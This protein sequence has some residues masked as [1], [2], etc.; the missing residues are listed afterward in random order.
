[1]E[2]KE[3]DIIIV[4]AGVAGL[5]LARLLRPDYRVLILERRA[6]PAGGQRIGESLP[7]A[8]SVLLQELGLLDR[9]LS[10][11][12]RM[13]G[14][15][16][17][18]WDQEFPVWQDA[19]RDPAGPGWLLDRRAF[20]QL[21]YQGAIEAGAVIQ[22]GC[23][24]IEITH[25]DEN[26]LGDG[27]HRGQSDSDNSHS[28]EWQVHLS[29]EGLTH[30]AP[31]LIDATGRSS[32]IARTLGLKRLA[33][34]SL[35]CLY[36]FLTCRPEDEDATLR[37]YADEHGWWYTVQ[38][39]HGK[40]VLAYHLEAKDPLWRRIRKPKTFLDHARRHPF[41][42]ETIQD[43]S[44]AALKIHPAG[45][46]MLDIANLQQAGRGFLAIGDALI[47]FDPIS[48][49]G[50]FHALATATSAAKTIRAGFPNNKN[51]LGSFQAEMLSVCQ[52][53]FTHLQST[54]SGPER[55]ADYP[56][57]SNRRSYLATKNAIV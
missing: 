2:A 46:A 44:A 27:S 47:T 5:A 45:T 25:S 10:G 43:L 3:W 19:L 50:M 30:S 9:F 23:R 15:A 11:T 22:N 4:G 17:S 38:I 20:D 32:S 7:G 33:D 42:A 54:Y 56:F 57:W 26:N 55:F 39:P 53:Y 21:L 12:H 28:N 18:V 16:L 35:L 52:R 41:L 37:T 34:D 6:V 13:R 31:V 14:S 40:R 49:Q 48:S 29:P 1:M 51:A 24:Q 36:T 8:A